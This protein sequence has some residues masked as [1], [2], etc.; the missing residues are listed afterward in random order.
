MEGQTYSGHTASGTI[1]GILTV[2]LVN[3]SS[4]D[5]IRTAIFAGVGAVVSFFISYGLRW[6][7]TKKR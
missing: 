4:G 2:F 5:L 7:I 3:I 1:G 6:M